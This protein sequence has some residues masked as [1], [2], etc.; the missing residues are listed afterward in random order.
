MVMFANVLDAQIFVSGVS[1]IKQNLESATAS[2][3]ASRWLP[4]LERL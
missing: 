1:E 4:T 3:L 2:P